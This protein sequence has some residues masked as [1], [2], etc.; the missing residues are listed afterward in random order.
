[1][2]VDVEGVPGSMEADTGAAVSVM[3]LQQQQELLPDAQLQPTSVALHTYT[4]ERVEVMGS[5]P[6]HVEYGDQ[7]KD[8]SL[9]IVNGNGPAL[10]G[11]IGWHTSV[12]TGLSSLTRPVVFSWKP[13]CKV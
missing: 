8:L 2:N 11:R 13:C 6:V 10:L 4:A 1:M 5:L 12:W 9:V 7:E 3:S